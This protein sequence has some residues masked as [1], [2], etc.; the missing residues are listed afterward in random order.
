M[1]F[2]SNCA[3][4]F[5]T[6][7]TTERE[8]HPIQFAWSL[9]QDWNPAGIKC[10]YSEDVKPASLCLHSFFFFFKST[11]YHLRYLFFLK[12]VC[13]FSSDNCDYTH[14]S[15][16]A[17][18]LSSSHFSQLPLSCSS[19]DTTLHQETS[20]PVPVHTQRTNPLSVP[21]QPWQPSQMT[22][23]FVHCNF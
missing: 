20:T 22:R 4:V 16:T 19:R 6:A 18:S 2:S 12:A 10:Q 9:R 21:I 7:K 1:P 17:K 8:E 3:G 23:I 14:K 5:V 13:S 15:N 11:P